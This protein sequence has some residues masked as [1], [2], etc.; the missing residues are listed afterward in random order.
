M[1][2]VSTYK[3]ADLI[4]SCTASE[5]AK[6][7]EFNSALREFPQAEVPT[8][9]F[10]HA[11][12]YARS[13]VV[14]AGVVMGAVEI[15]VPTILIVSG[16]CIIYNGGKKEEINGYVVLRG[17]PHRQVVI[18]AFTDTYMTMLYATSKTNPDECEEEFTDQ[19]DELITRRKS[20]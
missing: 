4:P 15:I 12:C 10:V 18:H 8:D 2:D 19:T 20:Q 16:H 5:L 6:V 9:H 3:N 17:A 7:R 11:G 1:N 13:C 14:K